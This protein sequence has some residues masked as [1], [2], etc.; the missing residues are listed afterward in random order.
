MFCP[1]GL[2]NAQGRRRP[3][4]WRYTILCKASG[5][6]DM[7]TVRHNVACR[8]VDKPL[9]EGDMGIWLILRNF[10]KA[11]DEPE[12]KTV[13]SRMLPALTQDRLAH[14]KPDFVIVKG[15][16]RN[17]PPP[18]EPIP[19]GT[20]R[21]ADPQI[22]IKIIMIEVKYSDDMHTLERHE[23]AFNLYSGPDKLTGKLRDA[24]WNVDDEIATTVV[25]YRAVVS[26]KNVDSYET[27]GIKGKKA[28]ET[29]QDNLAMSAAKWLHSIV[30]LTRKPRAQAATR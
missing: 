19:A 5:A 20:K 17:L 2:K 30:N 21:L 14:N 25:G 26:K 29:L 12:E 22:T 4:T 28:K 10:G 23:K 27:I 1:L 8:A 6:V 9:R 18:L 13:P 16:P 15:W 3:E 24:G 7:A 11:E